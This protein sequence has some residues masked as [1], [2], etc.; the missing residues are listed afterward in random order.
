MPLSVTLD[1]F[2]QSAHHDTT[3]GPLPFNQRSPCANETYKVCRDVSLENADS[4]SD[5]RELLYKYLKVSNKT[6]RDKQ[7]NA[8][9]SLTRTMHSSLICSTAPRALSHLCV[10]GRGIL[11]CQCS[12]EATTQHTL[13][14]ATSG[15][16]PRANKRGRSCYSPC[17]P[18]ICAFRVAL[19][20]QAHTKSLSTMH[21]PLSSLVSLS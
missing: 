8:K 16:G 13:Y 6:D 1:I 5:V 17:K 20:S 3:H 4:G 2:I 11:K 12:T 7:T 10:H 21:G 18:L 9:Q 15:R 19:C 14:D